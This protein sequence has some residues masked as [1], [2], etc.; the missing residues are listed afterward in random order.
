MRRCA[1]SREWYRVAEEHNE[2][3]RDIVDR[4]LRRRGIR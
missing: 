4:A 2:G 3:L 1:G